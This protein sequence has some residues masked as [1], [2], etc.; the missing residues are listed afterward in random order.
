MLPSIPLCKY[1]HIRPFHFHRSRGSSKA[2]E[3]HAM[4]IYKEPKN[5]FMY[6]L[7]R[8]IAVKL[9]YRNTN[10]LSSNPAYRKLLRTSSPVPDKNITPT[11]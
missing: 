7:H 11:Q 3:K 10:Q 1:Y 6:N 2:T 9:E 8:K 4:G 5:D